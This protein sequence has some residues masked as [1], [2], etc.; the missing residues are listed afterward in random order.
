[1]LGGRAFEACSRKKKVNKL[2]LIGA[3]GCIFRPDFILKIYI[4]STLLIFRKNYLR[5]SCATYVRQS[6]YPSFCLSV[7]LSSVEIMSFRGNLILI[8]IGS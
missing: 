8:F 1:M 6:V 4:F 2:V 3:F 7:R 5:L